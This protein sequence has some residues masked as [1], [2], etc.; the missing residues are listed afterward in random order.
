MAIYHRKIKKNPA[1]GRPG[2]ALLITVM[3]LTAILTVSLAVSR[4]A[5]QSAMMSRNQE[6]SAAAYFVAEAGAEKMVYGLWKADTIR[7]PGCA[8]G[9][10]V[11]QPESLVN[12]CP[13]PDVETEFALGDGFY[14]MVYHKDAGAEKDSLTIIGRYRGVKRAIMLNY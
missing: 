3:L 2:S 4:M 9:N 13:T 6:W 5:L 7:L 11:G 8:D 10:F 14:S 1:A 12:A